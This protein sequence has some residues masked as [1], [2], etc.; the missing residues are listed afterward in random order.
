MK[1]NVLFLAA[2]LMASSVLMAGETVAPAPSSPTAAIEQAPKAE[3][4]SVKKSKSKEVKGVPAAMVAPVSVSGPAA[5]APAPASPSNT[6]KPADPWAKF[7]HLDF[8]KAK[9]F[10]GQKRVLFVDARAKSEWDQGHIPGA[11]P[12]PLGEFDVYYEKYKSKISKATKL[13]SYCHGVGCHLSDKVAEKLWEKGH[14]N[15][16]VFFGG[17][18]QWTQNNLPVETGDGKLQA[19]PTAIVP[20]AIPTTK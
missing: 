13:I 4:K 19:T 9:E 17:W 15:T 12:V 10:H 14:K 11:I 16:Y 3:K 18:P 1:Q 6:A 5:S 2:A 8:A 20:A 7:Q